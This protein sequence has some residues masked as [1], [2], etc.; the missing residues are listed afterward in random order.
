MRRIFLLPATLFLAATSLAAA[1]QKPGEP[2]LDELQKT[3]RTQVA[4]GDLDAILQRRYLRA[5]V[6]PDR[7]TF[8]FDN[9][10]MYGTAYEALMELE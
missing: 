10:Q 9:G 7:L 2:R 4:R 3:V 6:V 1:Q 5:L 8:F